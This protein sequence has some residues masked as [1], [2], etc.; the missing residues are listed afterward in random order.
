[1]VSGPPG[2]ASHA[3][4]CSFR[5]FSSGS[6]SASSSDHGPLASCAY[7]ADLDGRP[8]RRSLGGRLDA[9]LSVAVPSKKPP[10]KQVSKAPENLHI[11]AIQRI[12]KHRNNLRM[13]LASVRYWIDKASTDQGGTM[14][15]KDLA[16]M[17]V[18]LERDVGLGLPEIVELTKRW[19]T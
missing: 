11:A 16:R 14:E 9:V 10:A 5:A 2:L 15:F 18:Q 4:R 6:V 8:Y 13:R 19:P 17:R 12:G 1:M 7:R 3:E